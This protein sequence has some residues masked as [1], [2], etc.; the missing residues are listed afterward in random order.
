MYISIT[1]RP[2]LQWHPLR[3]QHLTTTCHL[4]ADL[5]K[6]VDLYRD[7]KLEVFALFFVAGL[8]DVTCRD[9]SK[10]ARKTDDLVSALEK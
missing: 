5:V 7:R 10:I 8:F 2:P 6:N 9:S 3:A 1:G 4:D